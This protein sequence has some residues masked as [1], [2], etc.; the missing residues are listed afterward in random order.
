MMLAS[1]LRS[2]ANRLRLRRRSLS[3]HQLLLLGAQADRRIGR[4]KRRVR[5]PG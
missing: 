3:R 2:L 1:A 4:P 5:V